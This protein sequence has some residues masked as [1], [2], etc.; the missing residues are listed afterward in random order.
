MQ[1]PLK[2]GR[3]A[4]NELHLPTA[5]PDIREPRTALFQA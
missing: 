3:I 1:R 2:L 5:G 4:G